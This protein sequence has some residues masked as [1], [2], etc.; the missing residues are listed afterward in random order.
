MGAKIR[1]NEFIKWLE[2]YQSFAKFKIFILKSI[3][4]KVLGWHIY[5]QFSTLFPVKIGFPF[6]AQWNKDD[7]IQ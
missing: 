2:Y 5:R 3:I 4:N 6:I 1:N 7:Y